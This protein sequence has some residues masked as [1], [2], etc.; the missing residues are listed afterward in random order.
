MGLVINMLTGTPVTPG[1]ALG[2]VKA[3]GV[4]SFIDPQRAISA[5]RKL[6][7]SSSP[8]NSL[9]VPSRRSAILVNG[10]DLDAVIQARIGQEMGSYNRLDPLSYRG[11]RWIYSLEAVLSGGVTVWFDG[12]IPRSF[13]ESLAL[14]EHAFKEVYGPI[15]ARAWRIRKNILYDA[16]FKVFPDEDMVG[17]LRTAVE[18]VA[19]DADENH[20]TFVSIYTHGEQDS[21]QMGEDEGMDYTELIQTL[22]KIPG[23]KVVSLCACYS[24]NFVE[25]VKTLPQRDFYSVISSTSPGELGGNWVDDLFHDLLS[26]FLF[27]RLPLS[28]LELSKLTSGRYSQTPQLFLGFDTVF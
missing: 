7:S 26:R 4:L 5:L 11:G 17:G 6:T 12:P 9:F 1:R 13:Q 27:R 8:S 15:A 16:V 20:L 2:P 3:G 21:F 25:F 22:D 19:R 24:G 14:Y 28:H 18:Q 23:R 10:K